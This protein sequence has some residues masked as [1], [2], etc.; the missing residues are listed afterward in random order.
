[1]ATLTRQQKLTGSLVGLASAGVALGIAE[2]LAAITG[3]QSAPVIAVGG[4]VI[5]SVPRS[6]KEFATK[7]FGTHDK[8]ALLTGTFII[9]ALF[10]ALI[11]VAGAQ[12]HPIRVRRHRDLRIDRCRVRVVTP[13]PRLRIGVPIADRCRG[14]CRRDDCAVARL[15]TTTA[16]PGYQRGTP[17]RPD[18]IGGRARRC[19]R[20]R[21]DRAAFRRAQQRQ[22]G[23]RSDHAADARRTPRRLPGCHRMRRCP[24]RRR[25]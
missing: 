24:D 21:T 6:V 20:R 25:S 17:Y 8:T 19:V 16:G 12:G 22:P 10:A 18:R 14:R 1:M 4:V 7:T 13:R 23:P 15:A 2:V 3:P 5:D 11:G 9:L